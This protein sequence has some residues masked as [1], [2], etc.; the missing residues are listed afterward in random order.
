MREHYGR[1]IV[2]SSNEKRDLSDTI[3]FCSPEEE[4]RFT[5]LSGNVRFSSKFKLSGISDIQS[6]SMLRK[7]EENEA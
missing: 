5:H 4:L 3:N 6:K 7:E 1:S 2:P